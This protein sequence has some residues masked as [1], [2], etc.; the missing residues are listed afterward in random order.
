MAWIKE[1]VFINNI[2]NGELKHFANALNEKWLHL[3]RKYDTTKVCHEENTSSIVT[4]YPFVVPGGRFIEYYYWDSYWVIEGLLSCQMYDTAKGMIINF[5]DIVQKEG[6]VPNGSRI[7]YLDRSQPPMLTQMIYSYYKK[8]ND[9]E[10][11]KENLHLIDREYNYWMESKAILVTDKNN[12]EHAL[13]LYYVD[14]DYPRPESF[15][16]DFHNARESGNVNY[17]YSNIKTAAESGWDFSS[18]WF[19]DPQ[20]IRTIQIIDMIPV[21]L[22]AK[23]YKNEKILF[24]F[25]QLCGTE[26]VK[27]YENAVLAREEAINTILWDDE[28]NHYADYNYKTGTL[29]STNLY[30]SDLFPLW[31]GIKPPK[32]PESIVQVYH[33]LLMDHESGIPASD[34][35]TGQQWDFPNVWAP[36]HLFIVDYLKNNGMYDMAL[37]I[38]NR[39][40]NSVHAGWE[41]SG[42][43]YEKYHADKLGQYGGGGEYVVQEGFGWTNG[44]AINFIDWFGNNLHFVSKSVV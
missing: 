2:K 40:V 42:N 19:A 12:K 26:K 34:I 21:D 43:I 41:K 6:F 38:A 11:V 36:Y 20:D 4:R 39:F 7:Y 28:N 33:S 8:T 3:M 18:R 5:L 24:E 29:H 22:H 14:S 27:F 1:P 10:F 23:L 9:I 31:A 16:E 17:Y 25:H 30:A 44:V 37:N 32:S 35:E 13:N 15:E